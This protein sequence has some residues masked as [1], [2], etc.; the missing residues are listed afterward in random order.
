ME[1]L[2]IRQVRMMEK[3]RF[4]IPK[5]II[6]P[7]FCVIIAVS[8]FFDISGTFSYVIISILLHELGHLIA[9]KMLKI[10]VNSVVFRL[11]GI[12]IYARLP[13]GIRSAIVMLAGPMT[14][15]A[16]VVFLLPFALSGNVFADRLA[17]CSLLL[18]CFHMM[19]VYGL[20][21]GLALMHFFEGK[22]GRKAVVLAVK[23]FTFTTLFLLVL[24]TIYMLFHGTVN[25]SAVILALYFLLNCISGEKESSLRNFID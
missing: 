14:N 10:T 5:I 11:L 7:G 17:C 23:L 16:M 22:N 9:M 4:N 19:P 21:G 12:E 6:S 20:D 24:I 18:G 1:I 15:L 2:C 8:A 13:R 3:V 25:I